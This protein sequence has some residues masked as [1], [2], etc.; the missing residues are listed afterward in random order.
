MTMIGVYLRPRNRLLSQ[1]WFEDSVGGTWCKQC[2]FPKGHYHASAWVKT[3]PIA[4][5]AVVTIGFDL[6]DF[7]VLT[8]D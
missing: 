6:G 1:G 4:P 8:L 7:V 3:G 5:G 2:D